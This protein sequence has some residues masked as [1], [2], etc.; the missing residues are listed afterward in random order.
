MSPCSRNSKQC[1]GRKIGK[2]YNYL[3]GKD[4]NFAIYYSIPKK[5]KIN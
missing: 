2:N 3:I 4:N 5:C 1:N